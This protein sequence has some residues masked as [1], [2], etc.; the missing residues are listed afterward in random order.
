MEK[1]RRPNIIVLVIDTLREDHADGLEALRDLGFIKYENAIAPSPWTLPS[2]VS[3]VTGLYPSQHGV[4]E[5]YGVYAGTMMELSRQRMSKLNRGIIGELMEEGYSAYIISANPLISAAY[6]FGGVTEGLVAD[7]LCRRHS[8]CR[9][10]ERLITALSRREGYLG[11]AA[12]L[13]RDGELRLL[14]SGLRM[15]T[16]SRL[17][18]LAGR[19]GLHDPTMEKGSLA[20]L[21]FLRGRSF[22]E[23]FLMLI[24]IME[25]HGPYT[26]KDMDLRLTVRAFLEAVFFNRLDEEV[27]NLNRQS[28]PKHAAYAARRALEIIHALKGYLDRSLVIVT[29]DHGELLG[30]GGVHHGYF[31]KDGLL[32]VPLWVRWPSWARPVKQEG[33]FVSLAQVPSIVRGAV[34]GETLSLG[35][36]VVLAESFGSPN[37]P[38]SFYR[39]GE[40]PRE[41]LERAFSHRVRVYSRRGSATYNVRA[42]A[43][44]EVSG[45]AQELTKVVMEVVSGLAR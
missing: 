7:G 6:G 12:E 2:H 34:N 27:A 4:H 32:R 20:I 11:A 17:R 40:L 45:D 26:V 15:L 35:S 3:M 38:E 13:I 39:E 16:R 41:A 44:E 37:R 5:A 10:Y 33:A 19:L 22:T 18:R 28:Y 30:D 21:D 1:P 36:D 43:L 9:D 8:E 24:N 23:P 14:L 42:G 31:L 25:A 29:S